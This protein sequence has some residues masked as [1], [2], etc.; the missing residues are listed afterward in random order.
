MILCR[1]KNR[2]IERCN[3]KRYHVKYMNKKGLCKNCGE[4]INDDNNSNDFCSEQ[5][6]VEYQMEHY[7]K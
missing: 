6:G 4:D 2:K 3:N 5:C 7:R 1:M